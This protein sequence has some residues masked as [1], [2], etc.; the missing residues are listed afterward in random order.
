MKKKTSI[1]V[2]ATALLLSCLFIFTS[3][4]KKICDLFMMTNKNIKENEKVVLVNIDDSSIEKL[5]SFPW[6]RDI[7]AET[8]LVLRELGA[9]NIVLD[10]NFV[11]E[12]PYKALIDY[13]DF[14][15]YRNNIEI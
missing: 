5:G 7:Y 12:S 8:V 1:I 2:C 15:N 9:K 13:D 10:L 11:D 6:T 3:V 4:D 14:L